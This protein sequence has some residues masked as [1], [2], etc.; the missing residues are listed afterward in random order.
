MNRA[1]VVL[2]GLALLAPAPLPAQAPADKGESARPIV[3]LGWLVGGVWTA[4]ASK[5]G[6][7]MQRVETRYQWAD[8]NAYVR[9]NTH[10][11]LDKGTLNNYDGNLFWNP[12]RKTL[13]IW[14]MDSGNSIIEGPIELQGEGLSVTFR[15]TNFE[16]K[17]ADLRVDVSRKTPDLY[18]WAV[19]EKQGDGW[20]PL[21]ELDYRR[22][23]GS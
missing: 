3:A 15:G 8:N 14:Y 19:A 12:E 23:A 10:F 13:A 5:L 21:A 20:K 2:A 7:G 22:L 11:V 4:D 6:P 1:V 18:H 9:F 17:L 16:G